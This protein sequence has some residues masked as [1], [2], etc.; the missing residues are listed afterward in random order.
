MFRHVRT[1][2]TL[3]TLYI[4]TGIY[5]Y[6]YDNEKYF[7]GLFLQRATVLQ[8][9]VISLFPVATLFSGQV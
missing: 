5:L 1:V 8:H 7:L 3:H 6:L 2:G 4:C 9:K